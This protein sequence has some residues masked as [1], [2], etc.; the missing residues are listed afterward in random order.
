M[1][2][3][4]VAWGGSGGGGCFLRE[5]GDSPARGAARLPVLSPGLSLD[6]NPKV[7]RPKTKTYFPKGSK[8]SLN[9]YPA[10]GHSTTH[11]TGPNVTTTTSPTRP[12][13]ID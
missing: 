3:S 10:Q 13:L 1:P 2:V 9:S 8:M 12:R 11:L 6:P 4:L 7:V 5:G